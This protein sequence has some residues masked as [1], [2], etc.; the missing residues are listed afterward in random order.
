VTILGPPQSSEQRLNLAQSFNAV[1]AVVTPIIGAK[2]ILTTTKAGMAATDEVKTVIGTYVII[3]GVFVLI[4]ILILLTSLPETAREVKD[5]SGE[6]PKLMD[7]L[8]YPQL[9][10][11]V[12][13]QFAYVGAQVGVGSFI[14]RFAEY[15]TPDTSDKLAADYLKY[16]WIGFMIGRFAGA[17][18]MKYIQ[19]SRLLSLFAGGAFLCA[20]LALVASGTLPIWAVVTIGLFHS[21][22]FPTIFALGIKGLGPYTK[23]GSSLLVMAIIGG[24]AFPAL[25]GYVSD[26]TSIRTAFAV[27]L[28]CYL[29]IWYYAA[30]GSKPITA[31]A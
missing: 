3:A 11:G 23:L 12:I 5:E 13:A 10:K 4:A 2:F 28:F 14:I 20:C 8:R 18:L 29:Y 25:M 27:P 21:I 15:L 17:F 30:K 19:P 9:A 7:A 6:R 24:A 31:L 22:M 26:L 1:G 16:H